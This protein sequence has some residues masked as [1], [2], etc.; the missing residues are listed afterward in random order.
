MCGEIRTKK[1]NGSGDRCFHTGKK[2]LCAG[3]LQYEILYST[4]L[5]KK[6]YG[7]KS[8]LQKVPVATRQET[9]LKNQG[10]RDHSQITLRNFQ[11]FLTAQPPIVTL[12]E[13]FS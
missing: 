8:L 6:D 10:A 13:S 7:V 11:C 4:I 3:S 9:F 12:W 5:C 2:F 1:I